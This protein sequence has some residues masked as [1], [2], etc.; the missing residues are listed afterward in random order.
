MK[1][2]ELR[3]GTAINMDGQLYLVTNFDHVKPGKGPAYAQVKLKGVPGGKVLEKRFRTSEDVEQAVLDR[4]P[5]EYLYSEAD[6]AV[7]MD[8]ETYEQSTL[9]FEQL[10]DQ[11]GYL[12]ENVQITA[13]VYE[14]NLITI[15]FPPV[16]EMKV[17]DA[18]PG[19]KGA[20]VTGQTKEAEMETG[21]KVV[22]PAFIEIGEVIKVNTES[23]EYLGRA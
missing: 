14:G 20:T 19:I 9:S 1:A 12:K 4:R 23:G 13:L 10:G 3:P 21:L 11:K 15:E 18:P 16:V 8:L 6:G 7:F 2:Q 22:V 17:A 5:M